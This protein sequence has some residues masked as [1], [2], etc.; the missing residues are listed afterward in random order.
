MRRVSVFA[1]SLWLINACGS[2]PEPSVSPA[3]PLAVS[4]P[5]S[6][7][8]QDSVIPP[9]LTF[10]KI[11]P[12]PP[13]SLKG[14][15]DFKEIPLVQRSEK[16]WGL[17]QDPQNSL[18][19]KVLTSGGQLV[20]ENGGQS[21]STLQGSETASNHPPAVLEKEPF[22]SDALNRALWPPTADELQVDTVW[23]DPHS[24]EQWYAFKRQSSPTG[25]GAVYKSRD[26]GKSWQ[27]LDIQLSN[28]YYSAFWL[29]PAEPETL[30]LLILGEG[31]WRSQDGGQTWKIWNRDFLGIPEPPGNWVFDPQNPDQIYL[32]SSGLLYHSEDHG[33]SFK[34]FPELPA[35]VTTDLK[36]GQRPGA[37][38]L[39]TEQGLFL[40]N[41][42]SWQSLNQNLYLAQIHQLQ[43][44]PAHPEQL[45]GFSER[46][47]FSMETQT[48]TI[49]WGETLLGDIH[50]LMIEPQAPHRFYA[51]TSEGL[52]V[53]DNQG[54]SWLRDEELFVMGGAEVKNRNLTWISFRPEKPEEKWAAISGQNVSNGFS[55]PSV[56]NYT[57]I[58]GGIFQKKMGTTHWMGIPYYVPDYSWWIGI[59][60]I[61][62]LP[63]QGRK[64]VFASFQSEAHNGLYRYRPEQPHVDQQWQRVSNPELKNISVQKTIPVSGELYYVLGAKG[65][66]LKGQPDPETWVYQGQIPTCQKE[67]DSSLSA[68]YSPCSSLLVDPAQS[69]HLL[70]GTASGLWQSH[71]AGKTWQKRE[72]SPTRILSLWLAGQKLY[73]GTEK[74]L[75]VSSLAMSGH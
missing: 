17:A 39:G 59:E 7:A 64:E 12:S 49:V 6:G 18:K 32:R 1:L 58:P 24:S 74:G 35:Q 9:P 3:L 67:G 54:K 15:G 45:W 36:F 19:L 62:F 8:S 43:S 50:Q 38:Y 34:R 2:A 4:S 75:F 60:G 70:A 40:W 22:V 71:D 5:S 73:L 14:L 21:W 69:E 72:N 66:I 30:Y 53:S 52:F 56:Y 61:W 65:E 46:R 48:D 68:Q 20:S 57:L 44:H 10:P 29:D 28:R 63:Q 55:D 51:A 23:K 16:I 27:A 31:T 25:P 42:Q 47:I 13:I 26:G 41:G 37:F 33:Q 11:S